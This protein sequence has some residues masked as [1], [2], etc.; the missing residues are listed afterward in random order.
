LARE[1]GYAMSEG[2]FSRGDLAK[3]IVP[4]LGGA[5]V[6]LVAVFFLPAGTFDYWEAWV[7]IALLM[8]PAVFLMGYLARNDPA[9][10]ERRTRM[11]ERELQQRRIIS[12]SFVW[13]LAMFLLPGFDRR[14]EWSDVPVWLVIAADLLIALGYLLVALVYRENTYASRVVEVE[15]GQTV[16]STGP[17]AIVRHPMYLGVIGMYFF[18]PLAL[19]SYWAL[20]PALAIFPILVARIR[21]EEAVLARDLPGYAE[22][23]QKVRWRLIP[24]VW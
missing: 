1:E 15:K 14:F 8:V 4:R 9:L 16:I 18:T 19:G 17:Y 3:M 10:M 23:M 12:L 2:H 6:V 13:F 22:Y 24:G 5:V 7:Y 21:N 20:I 11:K